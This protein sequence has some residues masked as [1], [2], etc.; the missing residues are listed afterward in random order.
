VYA[1]KKA[2]IL[3]RNRRATARP[4]YSPNHLYYDGDWRLQQSEVDVI[5]V[6]LHDF[7]AQATN[8]W[9]IQQRW[10]VV[11]NSGLIALLIEKGGE[12]KDLGHQLLNRPGGSK[13][14]G[15]F[16]CLFVCLFV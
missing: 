3:G 16:V 10:T 8:D 9:L 15:D 2:M 4:V 7:C 14:L 13:K 1:T 12:A 5:D 11:S 6:A